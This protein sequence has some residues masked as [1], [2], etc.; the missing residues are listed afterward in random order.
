MGEEP[1]VIIGA[2]LAGLACARVLRRAG[3]SVR[4]Y[5]AGDAP[6][7]RV[8]SDEVDGFVLDR[9][10]QLLLP[11]YPEARR[12]LHYEELQLRPFYKGADVFWQGHFHRLADPFRHPMNALEHAL[13]PVAG[14]RDRW[15]TM[16]MLRET[17][18][19]RHLEHRGADVETE[20]D[21]RSFGFSD[22]FID[23][24][25]RP[26]FGGVFLER[27]LRTSAS[28]FRF[29]FAMFAR[30]GGAIPARGMRAIPEQLAADLQPGC[31]HFNRPA[32]RVEPGSVT[33][34]GG[35]VVRARRI[36]LA[37]D[38][39]AAAR[40]LS[41]TPPARAPRVRSTT[42]LYFA[43]D[44]SP[45]RDGILCLDGTGCGPVN[46]ACVLSRVAPELAP[47]GRHLISCSVLGLPEDGGNLETAVRT[48]LVSWF[49]PAVAQWRLL[50]TVQIESAQPEL[51]QMHA[52]AP[53]LDATVAPGL[54]RCGDYCEDVS[55]NGALLSGRRAA[56]A[57]LAA[58]GG[59]A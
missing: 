23:R 11:A 29:L 8:R 48:Q 36:V 30:G 31:L 39:P 10:F 15:T 59:L 27:D 45:T 4:I 32:A 47:P 55:I 3:V 51:R 7:G 14:M 37:V 38:E 34:A 16:L 50:R 26:F 25:F 35:E 57:V 56:E 19:L 22:G 1:V 24:F 54:F 43:A 46:H 33:L 44:E 2:G 17:R 5:E 52:S 40:L 58:D 28:M 42:C 18:R 53:V 41:P 12:V 49:G 9:G 21:L 20:D 13:D 6:G